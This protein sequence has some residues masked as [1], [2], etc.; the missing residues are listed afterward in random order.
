MV[1]GGACESWRDGAAG[2]FNH[3]GKTRHWGS[4]AHSKGM[5]R[6]AATARNHTMCLAAADA[7][8]MKS[9]AAQVIN[10]SA[11]VFMLASSM[12]NCQVPGWLIINIK[13][14]G[15]FTLTAPLS[16]I[17]NHLHESI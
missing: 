1:G 10:K 15:S 11:A 12:I 4:D 17:V 16:C 14:F 13:V 2:L 7:R 9:I 6:H 8:R 5:M 3:V